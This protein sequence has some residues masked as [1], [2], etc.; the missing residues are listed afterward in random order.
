MR[1]IMT[2]NTNSVLKSCKPNTEELPIRRIEYSDGIRVIESC[3]QL[4]EEEI[5]TIAETG[6]IYLMA[7]GETH[8]PVLL[9]VYEE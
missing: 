3:W 4:T 9:K 6:K 7:L 5:K 1:P 2:T 8:P